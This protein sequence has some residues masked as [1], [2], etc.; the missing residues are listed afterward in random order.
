MTWNPLLPS[1]LLASLVQIGQ[2][3]PASRTVGRTPIAGGTSHQFQGVAFDLPRGWTLQVVQGVTALSPTGAAPDEGHLLISNPAS[4]K[5]DGAEVEAAVDQTTRSFQPAAQ[6]QGPPQRLRFGDLEG[7]RYVYSWTDARGRTLEIRVHGFLGQGAG[8]AL[9]SYGTA[10]VLAQRQPQLLRILGSMGVAPAKAPAATNPNPPELVGTWIWISSFQATNGGGSQSGRQLTLLADGG[11]SY[12]ANSSSSNPYGGTAGQSSERGTWS[13]TA[14]ALTLVTGG[15]P[16][17][18]RLEKRN[19]PRNR[20]DPMIV[21][22][23]QAY[24]TATFKPPWR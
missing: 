21:L 6:R 8:C 18:Y 10:E 2:P 22:D 5:L 14:D 20:Q 4:R 3:L 1:L 11:F 13:A 16:R 23:G 7:R 24:V 15:V 12:V 17:T 9:V 19:H